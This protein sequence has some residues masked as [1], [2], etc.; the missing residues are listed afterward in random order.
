MDML[1]SLCPACGQPLR[2]TTGRGG[3]HGLRLS[4]GNGTR[5][6]WVH[7]PADLAIHW[8]Q[9]AEKTQRFAFEL[10]V[11]LFIHAAG[12]TDLRNRLASPYIPA[13]TTAQPTET[14]R[15][16]PLR[17]GG[18][19][20]PEPYAHQRFA[21]YFQW[22][23]GLGLHVS[24]VDLADLKPGAAAVAHL[25]GSARQT[26]SRPQIQA[27]RGFVEEGGVLLV[28]PAGGPLEFLQSA[29]AALVQAFPQARPQ[30][31]K[32]D[33]PLFAGGAAGM[34]TLGRPAVRGYAVAKLGPGA[35]RMEMMR[36]GKG[37]VIISHLDLTTGL[38]GTRSWGISGF[39]PT[40]CQ[41]LL[42]NMVLWAAQ[43][44]PPAPQNQ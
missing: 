9:R 16:T 18:A 33:H 7:S 43:G 1:R 32:L 35:G 13:V 25:S 24:P 22:E 17:Y 19:W 21:R 30:A 40:Y 44:T 29:Q 2:P 15:L 38:L 27:L 11:N 41:K 20:Q 3:L 36:C 31:L 14:L 26:F 12:K 4:R 10:G 8:Q 6:L 37:I 42:N 39:E 28:D 23:T 34:E 5:V